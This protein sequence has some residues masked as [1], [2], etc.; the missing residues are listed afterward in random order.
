MTGEAASA[1]KAADEEVGGEE[2]DGE[3]EGS[4]EARG[5]RRTARR[6]RADGDAAPRSGDAVQR[7]DERRLDDRPG[8]PRA[9]HVDLAVGADVTSGGTK[10]RAMPWP[11]VGEKLP[12][13]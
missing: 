1:A 2:V 10:P 6:T 8:E 7:A 3:K 4:D 11:S 13:T 12:L 5:S 9:A